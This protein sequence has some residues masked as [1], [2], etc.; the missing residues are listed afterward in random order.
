METVAVIAI[1]LNPQ[2]GHLV[3]LRT[4]R[5]KYMGKTRRRCTQEFKISVLR[6]LEAGKNLGQLSR[7]QIFILL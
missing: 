1:G 4:L 3:K 6:E 2:S 5:G 7:E